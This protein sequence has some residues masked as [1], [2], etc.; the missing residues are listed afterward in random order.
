MSGEDADCGL[1]SSFVGEVVA[2]MSRLDDAMLARSEANI[3]DLLRGILLARAKRRSKTPSEQRRA[4]EAFIRSRI[5]DRRLGPAMIAAEFGITPRYAHTLFSD[6]TETIGGYIRSLRLSS[7][8]EALESS[9]GTGQSLTDFA[10]SWGFYDLSHMSRCFR[11][12][13]DVTPSE[14][15]HQ[16]R[17]RSP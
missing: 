17:Q 7:C 15:R 16:A 3:M 1:L 10:L 5:T 2:R 13:F 11:A 6:G 14:I 9:A 12:A 8:R 4:I